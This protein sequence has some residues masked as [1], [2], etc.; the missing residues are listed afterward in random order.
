MFSYELYKVVH[1]MAI[2]LFVATFAA[3]LYGGDKGKLTKILGG[4]STFFILVGGMG[5]MARIGVPHNGPY[6][7]WLMIKAACWL[8]VAILAPM[9]AKRVRNLKFVALLFISAILGFAVYTAIF[10]IGSL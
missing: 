8:L 1:L 7:G 2:I 4:I 6:P 9:L 10:K 5:L 3:S